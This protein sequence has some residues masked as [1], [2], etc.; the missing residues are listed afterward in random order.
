MEDKPSLAGCRVLVVED[1]YFI[2]KELST[3]LEIE[4]A[5]VLGPLGDLDLALR[6]VKSDG[7]EVAVLDVHLQGSGNFEIADELRRRGVPFVFAGAYEE[8]NIPDRFADVHLWQKPFSEGALIEDIK[9]LCEGLKS[10]H[11]TISSAQPS[12]V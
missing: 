10:G 2:S 6:Q 12:S 7:F 9:R 8:G 1:E 5:K 4:G 3:L 11:Q